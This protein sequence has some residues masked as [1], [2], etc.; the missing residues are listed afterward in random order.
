[1]SIGLTKK[2]IK[3]LVK[4]TKEYYKKSSYYG[5][6]SSK[7]IQEQIDGNLSMI[8]LNYKNSKTNIC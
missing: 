8:F 6:W 2:Q 5:E 3:D 4:N 1:M 7:R